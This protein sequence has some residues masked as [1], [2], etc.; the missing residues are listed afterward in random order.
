MSGP[1]PAHL[2][3]S[4]GVAA[5]RV[6]VGLLLVTGPLVLRRSRAVLGLGGREGEVLPGVGLRRDGVG[7]SSGRRGLLLQTGRG[8]QLSFP[9]SAP[10]TDPISKARF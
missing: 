4:T 6:H 9:Q 1:R 2:D 10:R 3:C 7:L 8:R 5:V